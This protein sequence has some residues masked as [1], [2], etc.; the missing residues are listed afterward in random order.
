MEAA[1]ESTRFQSAGR[2]C[3]HL[4]LVATVVESWPCET[5]CP[6]TIREPF[7]LSLNGFFVRFI[8]VQ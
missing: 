3:W 4:F 5:T 8:E 2:S 1:S 7:R 6:S